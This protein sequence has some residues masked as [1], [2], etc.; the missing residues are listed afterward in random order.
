MWQL[1]VVCSGCADEVEV[2]VED[3]EDVEREVC[4]CGYSFIVL[5]VM[6]FEPMFAP[7]AAA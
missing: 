7:L 2:L 6:G 1:A 5:S 4:P 3:L